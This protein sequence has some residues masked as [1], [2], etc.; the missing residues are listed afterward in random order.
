MPL[1]Q[2][3]WKMKTFLFRASSVY[4]QVFFVRI[5]GRVGHHIPMSSLVQRS[6]FLDQRWIFW[7]IAFSRGLSAGKLAPNK[8]S[9]RTKA[10]WFDIPGYLKNVCWNKTF[11]KKSG[12]RLEKYQKN[13]VVSTLSCACLRWLF[14]FYHGKSPSNHDLGNVCICSK[15]LKPSGSWLTFWEC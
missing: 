1:K 3:G 11:V 6:M 4:F 12:E 14:T 8:S 15:H 5:Q 7:S 9:S 13:A 2:N 10:F